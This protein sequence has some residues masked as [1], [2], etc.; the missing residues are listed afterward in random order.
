[1][2]SISVLEASFHSLSPSSSTAFS[3]Q[4]QEVVATTT[5]AATDTTYAVTLSGELDR[6]EEIEV[7]V[8]RMPQVAGEV[9]PPIQTC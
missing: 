2:R 1:M 4:P 7:G 6:T 3:R 8:W 5:D 9:R